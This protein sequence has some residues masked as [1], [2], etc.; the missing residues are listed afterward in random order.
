MHIVWNSKA[1][2]S[3]D[4]QPPLNAVERKKKISST[5]S[6]EDPCEMGLWP[7]KGILKGLK[8]K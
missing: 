8:D 3:E 4:E 1:L 5:E 7:I 2:H 6:N